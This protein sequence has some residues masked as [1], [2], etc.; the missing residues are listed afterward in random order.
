[1]RE[2]IKKSTVVRQVK[3]PT[4]THRREN[5]REEEVIDTRVAQKFKLSTSS[6]HRHT[7]TKKKENK[8]TNKHSFFAHLETQQKRA[9][10]KIIPSNKQPTNQKI[11]QKQ[12]KNLLSH[13]ISR[14]E[15]VTLPLCDLPRAS[16]A[17]ACF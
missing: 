2:N 5:K 13:L 9:K 3:I 15:A 1:M 14:E 4:H 7:Q 6:E 16:F 17:P 8:K 10:P 12:K 11:K